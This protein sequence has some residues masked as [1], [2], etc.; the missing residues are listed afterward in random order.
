LR[1]LDDGQQTANS[2]RRGFFEG[3]QTRVTRSESFARPNRHQLRKCYRIG[4]ILTTQGCI[5]IVD[6]RDAMTRRYLLGL[7]DLFGRDAFGFGR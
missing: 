4:I 2:A 3:V 1:F 7:I 5:S 6:A